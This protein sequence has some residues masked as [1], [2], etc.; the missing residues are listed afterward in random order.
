MDDPT[1]PWGF[2]MILL[3]VA[4]AAALWFHDTAKTPEAPR[5]LPVTSYCSDEDG[6]F[7]RCDDP[8]VTRVY[9]I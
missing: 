2:F 6:H 1:R 4:L 7:Y 8:W 5:P 9:T 3:T